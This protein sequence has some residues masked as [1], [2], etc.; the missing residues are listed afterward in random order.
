MPST[1]AEPRLSTACLGA[2]RSRGIA[3]PAYNRVGD[4]PRIA[5][6][7]VGGFHRSHQALYVDELAAAGE[8][9][10][11]VGIGPL[12]RD[13]AMA[14]ALAAQ[15]LLYTLVERGDGDPRVQVIGSIVEYVHA[16]SSMARAVDV[17]SR[18]DVRIVSLTITEAGY[19]DAPAGSGTSVFDALAAGLERRRSAG[20][21]PVTVLSCDNI[22]HNGSV[23]R[24][25]TLHAARLVGANL[26][27]WIE[28]ECTFPNSMVDRITPATTD[29]DREWVRAAL[30]VD[31]RWPV[32]AEPFRQWVI[33][34]D[35]AGG[36]PPLE[37]VGALLTDRV[38][39][40]EL[41]KLRL[42]NATHSVLAYISALAGIEWVDD[43]LGTPAVRSLV[44]TYIAE[45]ALPSLAPIPGHPPREYAAT[46]LARF[47]AHGIRDQVTRLC[48]DGTVK[49]ATFIIPTVAASVAAGRPVGA[50]ALAIAA[51]AR[52]LA[53][54]PSEAQ[55]YD[56]YGDEARP[57]A[58][59]A[60]ADPLRFLEYRRVFPDGVAADARF[61]GAFAHQM[62]RL[63][64]EDPLT[65]AATPQA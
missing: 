21:D 13:R 7:G 43:A 35:F 34:D 27:S 53:V 10:R 62:Q 20:L 59:A 65:V 63:E 54:V 51:W 1:R 60:L 16:G 45:E 47:S 29:A 49:V 25:A 37:R 50:A 31:D 55:A 2:L 19:G 38:A 48:V 18:A 58:L 9:W 61:R 33:E 17:I 56:T 32:V 4:G 22:R 5:H 26:A 28:R 6:I 41:Y 46:V 8:P 57:Y 3:V 15:D 30:G 23:A 44:E 24:E 40:W 64:H 52:Y 42:L 36:R 11:I 39:D 12:E 14:E